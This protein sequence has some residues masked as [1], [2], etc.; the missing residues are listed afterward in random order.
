MPESRPPSEEHEH[1]RRR[2]Y[3]PG[4]TEHDRRAYERLAGPQDEP[5]VLERPVPA[6][7]PRRGSRWRLLAAGCG[8]A[9]V[10]LGVV[11]AHDV[12]SA[13]AALDPARASAPA[14]DGSAPATPAAFPEPVLLEHGGARIAAQQTSGGGSAV[15]PLRLETAP[16]EGGRLLVRLTSSDPS[17]VGWRAERPTADPDDAA[18]LETVAEERPALRDAGAVSDDVPLIG[19]PPTEIVVRAPVGTGWHLTVAFLR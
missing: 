14:W 15:V 16:A 13:P 18:A 2:L 11:A 8:V 9:V 1:L 17:P 6:R 10:A 7:I 12:R 5:L 4:A 19:R 3:R